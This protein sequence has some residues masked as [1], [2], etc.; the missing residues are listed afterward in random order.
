[1]NTTKIIF[2]NIKKYGYEKG[3]PMLIKG[4]D[5]KD[6]NLRR[7]ALEALRTISGKRYDPLSYLWR[8][9]WK[10]AKDGL[11]ADGGDRIGEVIDAEILK[12]EGAG[13]PDTQVIGIGME[14]QTVAISGQEVADAW[15]A[16]DT[17]APTEQVPPVYNDPGLVDTVAMQNAGQ[18]P[19][20]QPTTQMQ[21]Q[22]DPFGGQLDGPT[23]GSTAIEHPS[24][25]F[26]KPGGW[27]ETVPEFAV[28]YTMPERPPTE[29][30]QR[31]A[32]S[33]EELNILEY[34][35]R[36]ECA[37]YRWVVPRLIDQILHPDPEKRTRVVKVLERLTLKQFGEDKVSWERWW[38]GAQFL[39]LKEM[40]ESR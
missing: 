4:L 8:A 32:L 11:L 33:P 25:Q 24:D 26:G 39:N 12:A 16:Q 13:D 35:R 6:D 18:D 37:D 3:I 40:R 38:D 27:K 21:S 17:Q 20:S 19:F 28:P 10:D 7:V 23:P 14:D 30:E 5:S 36:V 22:H 29:E 31:A 15:A 9:W 1:M 34:V 2:K